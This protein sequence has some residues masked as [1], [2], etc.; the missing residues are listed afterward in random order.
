MSFDYRLKDPSRVASPALLFYK[1]LIRHN[2]ARMIER[3]GGAERLRPHCKTHKTREIVRMQLA[4]R[5]TKHPKTAFMTLVDSEAGIAGLSRALAET[6][7]GA[8]A[9]L[10][11]DI[12]Q[13]R[14]GVA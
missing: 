13:H 4:A 14:T 1:E 8:E 5:I 10:D 6:P 9:I 2:I 3:A 7:G 12:G 11:I